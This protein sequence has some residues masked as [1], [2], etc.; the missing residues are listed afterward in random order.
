MTR[1]LRSFALGSFGLVTLIACAEDPVKPVDYEVGDPSLAP[2]YS[3]SQADIIPNSYIVVL[4]GPPL[5]LKAT[6]S[7]LTAASGGLLRHTY[8]SVINGFSAELSPQALD[9]IR[10]HP[11]VAYVEADHVVELFSETTSWALDRIDQ[12]V[13]PLD[14]RHHVVGTG[15]GVTIYVLDTGIRTSHTDLVGRAEFGADFAPG[16][17]VSGDCNGHGTGVAGPAAGSTAGVAR[18]ASL[19]S[20]RVFDCDG[21]GSVSGLVAAINWVVQ[22]RSGAAIINLSGGKLAGDSTRVLDRTAEAAVDSGIVFVAA[23]GNHGIPA[24]QVSPA[25]VRRVITVGGTT[26]RDRRWVDSNRG[27]CV[28]IYAP[29]VDVATI[30]HE[31]DTQVKIDSG[32][33]F[34][35]P[36]VAGVAATLLQ[37]RPTADP[38]EVFNAII[39]NSSY[40]NSLGILYSRVG[41]PTPPFQHLSTSPYHTCG[42]TLDREA[43]CWGS[44]TWGETGWGGWAYVAYPEPVHGG[45]SFS[46]LSASS[47]PSSE[48][49]QHTCGLAA[50]GGLYCWGANDQ[51]QLGQGSASVLCGTKVG[52][53]IPRAVRRA[54]RYVDV[55]AGDG[56]TCAVR[57][58][59]VAFCWGRNQ[60]GFLHVGAHQ[61]YFVYSP[62]RVE[63]GRR[64]QNIS[65]GAMSTCGTSDGRIF[66]WGYPPLVGR[67]DTLEYCS[68][69]T[70]PPKAVQSRERFTT[71]SVGHWS[72]ACALSG[73][74]SVYC[75]G[76]NDMGQVGTGQVSFHVPTPSRVA[77][78]PPVSSIAIADK[79]SCALAE[80]GNAY[81]WGAGLNETPILSPVAV[82][83]GHRFAALTASGGY[84]L[85]CGAS[86]DHRV[87]CWR[88]ASG[89]PQEI[90][91]R[92]PF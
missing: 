20:V 76:Y 74:Q 69:L 9:F 57:D 52:S 33:S 91:G 4:K 81:C 61:P 17:P 48:H 8:E 58:D 80:T 66:C 90:S 47:G 39:A 79:V 51:G 6:A 22:N 14:G 77:N 71:V 89:T 83:G 29:A 55:S 70:C 54:T 37:R 21:K 62:Q 64:F 85:I 84:T 5:H 36:L 86:L 25:R 10:R 27:A 31:Y 12:R 56:S 40:V 26:S 78:L 60:S 28:D 23:A 7:N 19:V 65:T 68:E 46:K 45:L 82:P 13:T 34:A 16:D 50:S 38:G 35:A 88:G 67:A 43:F 44:S 2:L 1:S 11:K 3:A 18:G 63:T 92:P 73:N 87:L 32:T 41:E 72:H 30:G 75:W 42:L 53:C 49:P 59:G 15:A 24:C